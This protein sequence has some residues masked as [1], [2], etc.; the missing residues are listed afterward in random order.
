METTRHNLTPLVLAG[1][2]LLLPVLYL[3][4]YLLL[5][6]RRP[7]VSVSLTYPTQYSADYYRVGGDYAEAFY[8]PLEQIERKLRPAAWDSDGM[9]ICNGR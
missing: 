5:V 8:W 4:S 2:L 6:V 1:L 7:M 9:N 3:S